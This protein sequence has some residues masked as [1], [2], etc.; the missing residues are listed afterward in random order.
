[1]GGVWSLSLTSQGNRQTEGSHDSFKVHSNRST[2]PRS[3]FEK[4]HFPLSAA[5]R[6]PLTQ[7]DLLRLSFSLCRSRYLC[8]GNVRVTFVMAGGKMCL[9]SFSLSLLDYSQPP[10]NL[11]SPSLC[12]EQ[13][14]PELYTPP[15]V[16][17]HFLATFKRNL[18]F[19][20]SILSIACKSKA[21]KSLPPLDFHAL[22]FDTWNRTVCI[23]I[24]D[25][26]AAKFIAGFCLHFSTSKPFWIL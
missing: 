24:H 5:D 18:T 19:L 13:F 9:F 16:L 4:L 25:V 14:P 2:E 15:Q 17:P 12:L 11:L 6:F 20:S 1:M 8:F 3:D 23:S 21:Q 10:T 26:C 22:S 7:P